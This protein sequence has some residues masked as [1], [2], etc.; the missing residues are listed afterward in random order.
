[1]TEATL[2]RIC[3]EFRKGILD[4]QPSQGMCF[5]VSAALQRFL[6]GLGI[7][8]HLRVVGNWNHV[9][10]ERENGSVIDA[11]LD[12]FSID[13][14]PLPA[15]YLGPPLAQH[16]DMNAVSRKKIQL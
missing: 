11:A 10:L 14:N 5:V 9:W 15:V 4:G 8:T 16:L 13:G 12:Q 3:S 2:K 6:F 1:M 7:K